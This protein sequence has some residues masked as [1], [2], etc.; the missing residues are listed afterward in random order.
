[1]AVVFKCGVTLTMPRTIR[2]LLSN[3]FGCWGPHGAD[4][5]I[6]NINGGSGRIADRI[7]EPRRKTIVLTIAAPE[8]FRAGFG[9][10]CAE[11]RVRHDVDPRKRRLSV[12]P[13]IN[14]EFLPVLAK[15]AE[16][17]E[18]FQFHERQKCRGLFAELAPGQQLAR[19]RSRGGARG[20]LLAQCASSCDEHHPC[21]RL[22]CEQLFFRN[23]CCR[24]EIDAAGLIDAGQVRLRF[25][26]P[27]QIPSQWF[28]VTRPFLAHQDEI[29]LQAAQMPEGMCGQY[30]SHD[31]HVTEV[32]N[33]DDDDRQITRNALSPERSL[34]FGAAAKTPRRRSKLGLWKDNQAGELLKGLYIGT[35]NVQPA[36][37]KLGMGPS[38]LKRA[39][40]SVKLRIAPRQC[41][42]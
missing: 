4:L 21:S 17:V 16:A 28:L 18:V 7:V 42:N 14:D 6:A 15:A 11:L 8:T 3:R 1:M 33:H 27:A 39:R 25:G 2:I 19:F 30:L 23:F 10:Q 12:G 32:T 36:H 29:D 26:E 35:P 20:K 13:Q 5:V 34:T 31:F 37:L 9:N 41:D 22:K 40:A 24:A 38:G